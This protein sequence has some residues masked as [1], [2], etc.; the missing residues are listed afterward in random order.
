MSQTGT[1]IIQ[2][3]G[4][5][6]FLI[7]ALSMLINWKTHR[8][9]RNFHEERFAILQNELKTGMT[10]DEVRAQLKKHPFQITESTETRWQVLWFN[11]DSKEAKHLQMERLG[12]PTSAEL[13]FSDAGNLIKING[14]E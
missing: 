9:I 10:K 2:I 1:K 6:A 13:Q 14:L 12:V 4:I 11:E 3:L 5:V 7:L 8:E